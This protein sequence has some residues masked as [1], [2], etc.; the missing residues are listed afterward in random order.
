M[1]F[2]E[3]FGWD[4]PDTAFVSVPVFSERTTFIYLISYRFLSITFKQEN[5][6]KIIIYDLLLEKQHLGIIVNKKYD[7]IDEL[8]NIYSNIKRLLKIKNN[9]K[10]NL[11]NF[12]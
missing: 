6:Y 10:E 1:S 8:Y 9:E 11:R 5:N 7:S 12:K 2:F 4:L 3:W